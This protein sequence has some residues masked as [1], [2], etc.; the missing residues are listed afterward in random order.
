WPWWRKGSKSTRG[1]SPAT[2]PL[3]ASATTSAR[4]PLSS[5][6]SSIAARPAPAAERRSIDPGYLHR[7]DFTPGRD[8]DDLADPPAGQIK[9]AGAEADGDDPVPLLVALG[10][11][12]AYVGRGHELG[13]IPDVG[14]RLAH[15]LSHIHGDRLPGSSR[16]PVSPQLLTIV[17][18]AQP[19][20]AA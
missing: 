15:G 1:R 12:E 8:P 4:A 14:H 20:S 17:A 7:D 2:S 18:P 19:V 11:F 10:L 9:R 5:P 16:R 3:P 13:K 6:R